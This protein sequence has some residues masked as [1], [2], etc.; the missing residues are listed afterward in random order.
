MKR[1]RLQQ[2]NKKACIEDDPDN[3]WMEKPD[4]S[5]VINPPKKLNENKCLKLQ[6]NT[7]DLQHVLKG[8]ICHDDASAI[9]D[10][11]S[12][13]NKGVSS[14]C[15]K[16]VV[17]MDELLILSCEYNAI[18][19]LHAIFRLTPTTAET[20]FTPGD[21][22]CDIIHP[23]HLESSN[24]RNPVLNT[25]ISLRKYRKISSENIAALRKLGP[26]VF[27]PLI[28][29]FVHVHYQT[30]EL[31][32][33][34]S[35]I[36]FLHF[37]LSKITFPSNYIDSDSNKPTIRQEDSDF[38]RCP[39]ILFQ[40]IEDDRYLGLTLGLQSS[41]RLLHTDESQSISNHCLTSKSNRL[42]SLVTDGSLKNAEV[43]KVLR[44]VD[45]EGGTIAHWAAEADFPACLSQLIRLDPYLGTVTDNNGKIALFKN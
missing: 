3:L 26:T 1:K 4:T 42:V 13:S 36:Y 41:D 22:R 44:K 16:H 9:N 15:F 6:N 45:D 43:L 33:S 17:T 32:S 35:P 21:N 24:E 31:I 5:D 38:H 8:V 7:L 39:M 40:L 37:L 30:I 27:Q 25:I 10:L 2:L 18:H 28:N 23:I 12:M 11:I 19:I 14:V 29:A 34:F 20:N